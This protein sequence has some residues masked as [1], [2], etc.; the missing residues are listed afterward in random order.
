MPA[1]QALTTVAYDAGGAVDA[2]ALQPCASWQ[3]CSLA[4]ATFF[5]QYLFTHPRQ[6]LQGEN[7]P[8]NVKQL[9]EHVELK[10][11]LALGFLGARI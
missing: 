5:S 9:R 6:M 11:A 1:C 7:C 3:N 4:V 10:G 8:A 2:R